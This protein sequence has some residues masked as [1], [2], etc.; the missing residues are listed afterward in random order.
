[1]FY[2]VRFQNEDLLRRLI[3]HEVN[4][5]ALNPETGTSALMLAAALGYHNICNIL[6]D[7]GADLN[8]SDHAGNTPLHLAAHG[9]GEQVPVIET[10]LQR[11]ADPNAVNEDGFTPA[12]L[13]KETDNEACFK[14]LD[15]RTDNT[16]QPPTYEE[17]E[18]DN[19]G[20]GRKLQK[21]FSFA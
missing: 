10:L 16:I 1:M 7:A 8:A 3:A 20:A 5:N 2:L 18:D 21:I 4:I 17:F 6:I 19:D 11:G 9:Y 14:I 13:A 15:S 12:A